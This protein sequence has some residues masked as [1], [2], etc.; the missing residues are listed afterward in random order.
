[1]MNQKGSYLKERN[2][3]TDIRSKNME[4]MSGKMQYWESVLGK[5]KVS[6]LAEENEKIR[7]HLEGVPY[8]LSGQ[9]KP[10]GEM[11]DMGTECKKAGVANL[12]GEENPIFAP[13]Y[14]DILQEGILKFRMKKGTGIIPCSSQVE[15]D[16]LRHTL[17]CLQKIS[18]RTLILEMRQFKANGKLCGN[19]E[20]QEYQDFLNRYLSNASYL[21]EFYERYPVL[22]RMM[23]E[24]IEQSIDYFCEIMEHLETDRQEIEMRLLDGM[25]VLELSSI[26][27]MYGD[28]H[29]HGKSVAC[30]YLNG[31][32]E[33]VY[34]PHSLENELI[35]QN[36][37]KRISEKYSLWDSKMGAKI[38]S[39][40]DYGWEEKICYQEC[41]GQAEVKRFY[42]RAGMQIFLTC[43]LGASDLHCENMIARGEYPVLI[44]LETVIHLQAQNTAQD[45][46]LNS[47]LGSGILPTYLP[48]AQGTGN[49]VGALSGEGGKKSKMLMPVIRDAYSSKMRIEYRHGLMGH[50][51][52]RVKYQGKPVETLKYMGELISG[53]EK[54]YRCVKD[55]PEIQEYILDQ[56]ENCRSRQL[57]S[58]TMKYAALLNSSCYPDLLADGGDRELFIRSVGIIGK[59]REQ[60]L[61]ECEIE[62]M[63]RGD[64]PYFYNNGKHLMCDNKICIPHYFVYTP[65]QA[66]QNRMARLSQRDE[67][68]QVKLIEMSV[69]IA[70]KLGKNTV[71]S[72]W[73]RT[74]FQKG[75]IDKEHLDAAML[76]VCEKIAE[77]IIEN[78][79]ED[80]EGKLQILSM[81]L[82][83]YSRSKIRKVSRYFYE[84]IAGIVLFLY[85]LEKEAARIQKN[86]TDKKY[87]RR[88]RKKMAKRLLGQLEEY[89]YELEI[90]GDV[91]GNQSEEAIRTGLFDGEFSI[92]FL[93]L[94]LYG[95][96]KEEGYL[97]LAKRHAKKILPLIQKDRSFDLVGG[98]AGGIIALLKLYDIT[99]DEGYL[100]AAKNAGDILCG[101]AEKM[102][103]GIGWRGLG[104]TPLCGMAHGNS[105]I[106]VAF[107]RLYQRTG[108]KRFYDTC[109]KCLD[110]ENSMYEE[111]FYDWK[112]LRDETARHGH[113]GGLEMAWCHGAGGIALSRILA[114]ETLSG[115][116]GEETDRI[117]E[118][119]ERDIEKAVHGLEEH[120]LRQGMCVCHGT[121]GNYQ[122]LKKLRGYFD[123]SVMEKVK[124][125]V[126]GR[127]MCWE[128]EEP[129]LLAQ[130]YHTPGFMNGLAG[131]G[132]YLLKE[133]DDGLPDILEL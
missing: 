20:A 118:R 16:F 57:V 48:N 112:D 113:T 68:F 6:R 94:L 97:Q 56:A 45:E 36:L 132:Y 128:R 93:Y 30:V 54:A 39:H 123:G 24:Q 75:A 103:C 96:G 71:N 8:V 115:K 11:Q 10:R 130:E 116:I 29:N 65:K 37:L 120:F 117:R 106:L 33:V 38:I 18:A 99:G 13:F 23:E 76:S 63:L 46:I 111:E 64:I 51:Q 69:M 21:R 127:I 131:I 3:F 12:L 59:T 84:G 70:G 43:L 101:H 72:E 102:E 47:V 77:L 49:E 41:R 98:N 2:Y 86:V 32:T 50:T 53:F 1:M 19:D 110:Y 44:D 107:A 15:K 34:K 62:A 40:P 85:A 122:I 90:S 66:V 67:R 42:E 17:N 100:A 126:Y 78:V 95:I 25:P 4:K 121:L 74:D 35:F 80:E 92:V 87:G 114:I 60:Q 31:T 133:I 81:D 58:D 14:H 83:E 22:Y 109:L 124:S 52:N 91:S 129:D 73:K 55:N 26:R 82:T 28:A 105:G 119:L 7:F 108:E 125:E 61:V 88:I 9:E 104:K 27:C 89:T 5:D 79:Y